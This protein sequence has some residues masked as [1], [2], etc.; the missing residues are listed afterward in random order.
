MNQ[1]N[2][3][4]C[5]STISALFYRFALAPLWQLFTLAFFGITLSLSLIFSG[6]WLYQP[7][8]T[9]VLV[10]QQPQNGPL[11]PLDFTPIASPPPA[12]VA[13]EE[14][15]RK[16]II[17]PLIT[18]PASEMMINVPLVPTPV[19]TEFLSDITRHP[20]PTPLP[21][22]T[23]IPVGTVLAQ[24]GQ[25]STLAENRL[26]TILLLGKDA[27]P[28]EGISRT[29][30]LIVV[31][32]NLNAK[33]A[34]L[35]SIPRDLWVSM[36]GFGE[37]RINTAYFL[38]EAWSYKGGGAKLARQTISQV[39]GLSITYSLVVDFQGFERVV[40]GLDGI[41]IYVPHA[42]DDQEFPDDSY[43]TYHLTI[44]SGYQH[45]D[46]KRALA[47]ARTR[48]GNSDIY[49][50]ERQQAVMEAV[51]KRALS[52]SYLPWLPK[53]LRQEAKKVETNLSVSDLFFLAR[54]AQELEGYRI[55]TYVLRSPL[56]W[57]G[58]TADGQMVLLYD[59]YSLQQSVHQWL[60]DASLPLVTS[61]S[62]S[63]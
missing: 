43:G 38:G 53:I 19:V 10:S 8:T 18:I 22:I 37:G 32:L 56:L 62:P 23:P 61:H 31:I 13:N 7:A 60:Y 16:E 5:S 14:S 21:T 39:L 25:N 24:R 46:G 54:F 26:V 29:D 35:I 36:P 2:Y 17:A 57:N 12:F 41:N 51:R 49:R 28:D 30:T 1:S 52:S 9:V 55:Y 6:L 59:P 33:S 3:L 44:P 63:P 20:S 47:Y 48:H 40:D 58:T 27:R 45:M 15:I 34:T 4:S 50:A 11:S 42:I